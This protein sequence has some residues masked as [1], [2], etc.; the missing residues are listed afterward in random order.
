VEKD[1][2]R[3]VKKKAQELGWMTCKVGIDGYPDRLF[4]KQNV[5]VWVEFKT[6]TGKISPRQRK[7]INEL[8]KQ[9]C[10]VAV[11]DDVQ[12]ALMFLEESYNFQKAME[13][14]DAP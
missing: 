2:E 3:R 9:G 11:I 13:I 4:I 6:T 1:L 12:K 14:I 10:H 8:L 7:R 5:Y